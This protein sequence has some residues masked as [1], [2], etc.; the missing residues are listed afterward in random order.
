MR[1]H[2]LIMSR[3]I[4]DATMTDYPK[5]DDG[6]A[7]RRVAAD[8]AD[9]SAPMDIDFFVAVPDEAAGRAVATSADARGYRTSVDRDED[10]AW[11]CYCTRSMLATYDGVVAA[12][13]ELGELARPHGGS[14][15]GWGT[16]GN[17]PA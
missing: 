15:D 11:T 9:M 17:A 7:L 12:Q 1:D 10:G 16:F 5:D 13:K 2:P 3:G 14:P 4:E 8:G 6:D